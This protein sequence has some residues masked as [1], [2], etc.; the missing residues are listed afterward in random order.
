LFSGFEMAG[1]KFHG[2]IDV[3]ISRN[4]IYR[5]CRG[6][7][8]DWMA[9]GTRV[10][11]N[12]FHENQSGDLFV[13]TDHGP[14]LVD[15]NIFLSPMTVLVVS[16]GGAYVHNWIAGGV[17]VHL[18]AGQKTPFHK[19]HSTEIAGLH[20]T[21]AG[22]DRYYNNLFVERGNLGQ[23]DGAR[24]PVWMDGNVFL[25]GARPSK[26][27]T[28]PLLK[29]EFDPALKLVEKADGFYIEIKFDKAW[30]AERTRKLV[31]TELLGKAAI[32]NLP[33]EQPDGAPIRINTDYFGKQRNEANPTPGPFENPG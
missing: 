29:P 12:L 6:L 5:T 30:S 2:A 33:Y 13:E 9:Q 18:F 32:P 28:G 25:K 1:I 23:Y 19:A 8:L 11:A 26:H 14:F 31:T 3:E 24:L 17:Q 7:W 27:E 22:D 21:P 15:N 10:T 4:H 20:D 16:H